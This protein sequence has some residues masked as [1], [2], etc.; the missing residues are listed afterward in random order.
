MKPIVDAVGSSLMLAALAAPMSCIPMSQHRDLQP[1]V[2]A[3]GAYALMAVEAG[4][5][6]APGPADKCSNC[7]GVGRVSDGRVS[8]PCPVCGGTG[9][10]T[11]P[12][13]QKSSA[14]PCPNGTCQWPTRSIVR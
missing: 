10:P 12:S 13:Q 7:N 4:P 5:T 3:A 8:V 9:K 6:P 14:A 1:F 2:A 11:R